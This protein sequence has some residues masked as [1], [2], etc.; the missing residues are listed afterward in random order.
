MN[1]TDVS[2]FQTGQTASDKFRDA[3]DRHIQHAQAL[4]HTVPS[5][6]AM[7]NMRTALKFVTQALLA[8]KR[9]PLP[10][11]DEMLVTE[12]QR[13]FVETGEIDSKFLAPL[14]LAIQDRD[15][16]SQPSADDLQARLDLVEG[17]YSAAC[18]RLVQAI[19]EWHQGV[20]DPRYDFTAPSPPK[21]ADQPSQQILNRVALFQQID[22]EWKVGGRVGGRD[23]AG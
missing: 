9:V 2:T 11:R 16:L 3:A 6:N 15:E 7:R 19:G 8:A 12:L 1:E 4:L 17:F 23:A 14:K 18:H 20:G 10:V 22:Q 5:Q 13:L 21:D